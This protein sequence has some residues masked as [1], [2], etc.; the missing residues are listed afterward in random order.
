MTEGGKKYTLDD[1][2]TSLHPSRNVQ[3]FFISTPAHFVGEFQT[4]DLLISHAWPIFGSS[5]PAWFGN[6][7]DSLS[8]TIIAVAYRTPKD[9]DKKPHLNTPLYEGGGETVA[10][11]LSVLFG[12]RF[13]SHGPFEMSGFF[14]F[15]D[16]STFALPCETRLRHNDGRPR[17]N[18]SVPLDFSE[19]HRIE[20]LLTGSTKNQKLVAF[21]TAARFYRRSLMTF[22]VDPESAYLN[23]ITAGEIVASFHEIPEAKILDSEACTVLEQI[24]K[25]MNNGARLANFLRGRLRGI[26]RRFVFSLSNMVDESFF[27]RREAEWELGSFKKEDFS[28]RIGAAYDL[29]SRFVHSGYPFGSWIKLHMDRSEVPV[30]EPIVPDRE[31][32]K[33]LGKA[34]LFNGLER[35]IRYALLHFA[36]QLGAD[37]EVSGGTEP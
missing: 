8:R 28:K 25:E 4:R 3:K 27:D 10:S 2:A 12:K 26:K 7:N 18:C 34:P 22:D 19:I 23:L 21:F 1:A 37:L 13:D 33:A 11:A 35:V 14:G 32:A 6:F 16:T 24:T 30:G 5:K 17:A 31:M 20:K 15:P 36:A 9:L 29:R